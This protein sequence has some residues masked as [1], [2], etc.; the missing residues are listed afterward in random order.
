MLTQETKDA[1]KQ[2]SLQW[3]NTGVRYWQ[4]MDDHT[5]EIVLGEY[6]SVIGETVQIAYWLERDLEPGE[7]VLF[8][9]PDGF[10]TKPWQD[11]IKIVT[12]GVLSKVAITIKPLA[13]IV[14]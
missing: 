9:A 10:P 12:G 6:E 1:N 2:Y 11:K 13:K 14:F 4:R 5:G 8:L 3:F 7:V